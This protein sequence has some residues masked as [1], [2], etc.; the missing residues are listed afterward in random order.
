MRWSIAAT[1]AAAVQAVSALTASSIG[2]CPALSPRK[3]GA[4]SVKDLRPDD[5][6]VIG[7]MGDRYKH[8]LAIPTRVFTSFTVSWQVLVYLVLIP[9]ALVF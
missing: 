4:T 9:M 6:K 1:V 5:I 3:T 8:T 7:A 2:D